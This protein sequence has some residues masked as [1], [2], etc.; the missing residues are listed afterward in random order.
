MSP[1]WD[2]SGQIHV[3][4][5]LQI[6]ADLPPYLCLSVCLYITSKTGYCISFFFSRHK[7]AKMGQICKIF[8]LRSLGNFLRFKKCLIEN[9]TGYNVFVIYYSIVWDL[10]EIAKKG[11]S[12]VYLRPSTSL[13]KD[14]L[15][16]QTHR[17][18]LWLRQSTPCFPLV[19][20]FK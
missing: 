6:Q 5:T 7:I 14:S 17:Q 4:S 11:G 3:Y 8:N 18:E 12:T 13:Y 16:T 15:Y 2:T 1:I 19:I 9:D 20:C 10:K